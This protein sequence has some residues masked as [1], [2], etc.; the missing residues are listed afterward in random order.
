MVVAD[1]VKIVSEVLKILSK[2]EVRTGDYVYVSLYYDYIRM[3]QSRA[4]YRVAV[5]ELA[6]KYGIGRATVERLIK[7]FRRDLK[8]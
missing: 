7:R 5:D 3:R 1:F 6:S 2:N 4:K 8:T